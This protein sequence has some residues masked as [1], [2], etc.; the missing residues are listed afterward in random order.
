MRYGGEDVEALVAWGSEGGIGASGGVKVEGEVFR[1]DTIFKNVI[2][3]ATVAGSEPNSVVGEIG[4]GAVG[5][6]ID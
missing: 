5:A 1:E 2:E 4:V 6:E 3:E